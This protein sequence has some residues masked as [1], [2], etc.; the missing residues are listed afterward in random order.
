MTLDDKIDLATILADLT[1]AE[2]KQAKAILD[3]VVAAKSHVPNELCD[4]VLNAGKCVQQHYEKL[5]NLTRLSD[6][7]LSARH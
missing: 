1:L 7:E 2:A 6:T 4:R 5:S 3:I